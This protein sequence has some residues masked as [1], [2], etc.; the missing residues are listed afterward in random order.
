M[1]EVV[2]IPCSGIGKVLGLIARE[3]AIETVKQCPGQA[4]S[5]CLAH[6]VADEEG[7]AKVKG[8]SCVTVDGCSAMCAAKGAQ[9]AGGEVRAFFRV[10][11]EM[12]NH[13]GIK[14]GTGTELTED[15]WA[16]IDSYSAKIAETVKE[17]SGEEA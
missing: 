12:K 6:L 3:T 5:A 9:Y 11:D 4:T 15:G 7:A 8:K 1:S 16:L 2:V 10:M 13:R 14:A 17:I